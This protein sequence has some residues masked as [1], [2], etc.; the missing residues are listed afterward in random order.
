MSVKK[1]LKINCLNFLKKVNHENEFH[2]PAKSLTKSTRPL[3][4][5]F[6]RKK[7][8]K[9][10]SHKKDKKYFLSPC[11]IPM[12]TIVCVRIKKSVHAVTAMKLLSS[13]NDIHIQ[14][15]A[16]FSERERDRD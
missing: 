2:F 5:D 4:P 10:N 9:K 15:Q 7:I 1:N 3:E 11:V 16:S 14:E 6:L 12:D 13:S 8:R